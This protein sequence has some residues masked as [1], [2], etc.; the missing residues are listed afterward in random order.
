MTTDT[1]RLIATGIRQQVAQEARTVTTW[2]AERGVATAT[3]AR[4]N[5]GAVDDGKRFKIHRGRS[6]ICPR[7]K[8]DRGGK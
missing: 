5:L 6:F 1:E 3:C 2:L 4:C 7:C 8:P